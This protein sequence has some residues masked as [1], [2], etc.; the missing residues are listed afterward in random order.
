MPY[1]SGD[2]AYLRAFD[3]I[4]VPAVRAHQPELL[5]VANGQDANQFDPNGRQ[6]LSMK[7]FYELGKRA[8]ALA[9]ECCGGRLVLAQEGGYA[10]SYAAYCLH[11]SLDGVLHRRAGLPD[12]L[13]YMREDCT[14]LN[15]FIDQ[16]RHRYVT[17]VD[18]E[19]INEPGI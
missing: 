14:G 7:G 8:R 11:A 13:A 2:I 15:D 17:A 12:P 19:K 18:Q 4:I 16:W 9:D 5:F 1:G 10:I 6:L 3:E